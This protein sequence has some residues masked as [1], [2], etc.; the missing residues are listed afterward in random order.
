MWLN[1]W[2]D[3][4]FDFS[5]WFNASSELDALLHTLKF[6]R[7]DPDG[8]NEK[9]AKSRR[10]DVLLCLNPEEREA[11][12]NNQLDRLREPIRR[13]VQPLPPYGF[14]D[15]HRM[16]KDLRYTCEHWDDLA[17]DLG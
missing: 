14:S 7:N 9:I 10:M 12:E 8:L 13:M 3:D 11:L 5:P 2:S 15:I 6:Y 17:I 1:R 16:M 4:G